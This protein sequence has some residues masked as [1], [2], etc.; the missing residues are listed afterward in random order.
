MLG[1]LIFTGSWLYRNYE[2]AGFLGLQSADG[3]SLLWS[4]HTLTRNST[5]EDYRTNPRLARARDLIAS[6]DNPMKLMTP[7]RKELGL[8]P[9]ELNDILR[10]IGK[11]NIFENPLEYSFIYIR[12]WIKILTTAFNVNRSI[13][14]AEQFSPYIIFAEKVLSFVLFVIMPIIGFVVAKRFKG[15]RNILLFF[16]ITI[17]FFLSLTAFVRG[18][19]RYRLPIHGIMW[20]LNSITALYY[21]QKLK[22]L[23]SN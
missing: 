9:Y 22:G 12:N 17:L 13:G 10:T 11:E 23:F 7:I 21:Y 16:G 5:V 18:S 3:I 15:K 19:F 14:M 1:I 20:C 2:V 8:S 6:G 4:N